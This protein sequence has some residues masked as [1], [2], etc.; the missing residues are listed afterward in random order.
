MDRPDISLAGYK[1]YLRKCK[2]CDYEFDN[3]IDDLVMNPGDSELRKRLFDG[4]LETYVCPKCGFINIK[5][6]HK[7]DYIDDEKKFKVFYRGNSGVL[8]DIYQD[9]VEAGSEANPL[10]FF[11]NSVEEDD[12]KQYGYSDMDEVRTAICSLENDLDPKIVWLVLRDLAYKLDKEDKGLT[13]YGLTYD[14]ESNLICRFETKEKEL[15]ENKFPCK[16]YEEY[17]EKYADKLKSKIDFDFGYE[18]ADLFLSNLEEKPRYEKETAFIITD[19]FTLAIVPPF[20][21]HFK[22]GEKVV[23][24]TYDKISIEVVRRKFTM[25]NKTINFRINYIEFPF[26]QNIYKEIHLADIS[27]SAEVV[28]DV[29]LYKKLKDYAVETKKTKFPYTEMM[30][31]VVYIDVKKNENGELVPN[32]FHNSI[33]VSFIDPVTYGHSSMKAYFKDV[34]KYIENNPDSQSGIYVYFDKNTDDVLG[35]RQESLFDAPTQCIMAVTEKMKV[36]LKELTKEDI[37]YMSLYDYGDTITAINCMYFEGDGDNFFKAADKLGVDRDEVGKYLD[38]GYLKLQ[39]I[40]KNK[41]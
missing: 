40:V 26:V 11:G 28:L 5:K 12:Y 4:T 37:G 10:D 13:I 22:V 33:L 14:E 25:S 36:I 20:V 1:R 15:I 16:Q 27:S 2:Q 3:Y 6:L 35:L 31:N 18:A 21:S 41:Y 19:S 38:Y 8:M 34:K 24:N 9:I 39:R 23:I 17:V 7:L 32:Y 29:D 30:K